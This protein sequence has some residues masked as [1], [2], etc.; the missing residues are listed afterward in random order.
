ML[1]VNKKL[2]DKFINANE[3][4]FVQKRAFFILYKN[5]KGTVLSVFFLAAISAIVP[6]LST[7]GLAYLVNSIIGAIQG[8][9]G[10]SVMLATVLVIGTNA[11][12]QI[13]S[14]FRDYADRN[15]WLRGGAYLNLIYTKRR[16]DIDI[17]HYE[18]PKLHDM[19]QK[20]EERGIFPLLNLVDSQAANITNIVGVT[21]SAFVLAAVDW[22]FLLILMLGT[23]PRLLLSMVYGKEVWSIYDANSEERRRYGALKHLTETLQAL[24]E[25]RIHQISSVVH[26]KITRLLDEF[27]DKQVAVEKKKFIWTVLA[28][29]ISLIAMAIVF[30]LTVKYAFASMI[31][32]GTILFIL[33]AVR[34]FEGSLERFFSGLGRMYEWHLFSREFFRLFDLPSIM[35]AKVSP[36][37]IEA[38]VPEVKFEHVSF[39]YPGTDVDVLT[40]VS[41][42]IPKGSSCALVGINGAGKSTLVKLLARFYDPTEGRILVNGIDLREIDI[43]SWYRLLGVLFQDYPT[44]LGLTV[45]S[46][47][48][49]GKENGTEDE[50]FIHEAAKR[51]GADA[52]ITKWPHGYEEVMGKQFSRGIDPSRG[53]L[54]RLAMARIFYRSP[55]FVILDEPTAAVDAEAEEQIFQEIEATKEQTRLLISHRFST[56]RN[57]DQIIILAEGKVSEI[58]TH[59]ELMALDKTYAKLFQ[60]QA[61]GY[62]DRPKKKVTSKAGKIKKHV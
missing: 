34:E 18:D 24:M 60:L 62:E 3:L 26:G 7:G 57:T 48:A 28:T 25:M 30:W 1:E 49:L 61:K 52:F 51:A 17:A 38:G 43:E 37:A 21:V 31:S 53:Q 50:N 4:W 19:L 20:I 9:A 35:P 36:L 39:R 41:F 47:I 54:Q 42:T 8:Q 22:R 59:D 2:K 15:L 16:L 55:K 29:A 13:I 27:T 11:L 10:V 33:T 46:G 45:S 32:A 12:P 6:F 44:Y 14:I 40:D 23:L 58:G 56:V 5:F